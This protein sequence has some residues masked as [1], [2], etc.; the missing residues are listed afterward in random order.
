MMGWTNHRQRDVVFRKGMEGLGSPGVDSPVPF[1][2]FPCVQLLMMHH[3][4][5]RNTTTT[6]QP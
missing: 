6:T 1:L 3:V 4:D 2:T 5:S